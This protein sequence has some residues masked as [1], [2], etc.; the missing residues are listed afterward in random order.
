MTRLTGTADR[1]Y[2]PRRKAVRD[3]PDERRAAKATARIFPLMRPLAPLR[4]TLAAPASLLLL[5]PQAA[6]EGASASATASGGNAL[7]ALLPSP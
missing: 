1:G 5:A 2:A 3:P 4:W 7:A 6:A